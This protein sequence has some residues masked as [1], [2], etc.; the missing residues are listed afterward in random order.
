MTRAACFLAGPAGVLLLWPTAGRE[1]PRFV[2]NGHQNRVRR[3][4]L[5]LRWPCLGYICAPWAP[6]PLF[7]SVLSRVYFPLSNSARFVLSQYLARS[8]NVRWTCPSGQWLVLGSGCSSTCP[9]ARRSTSARAM[10]CAGKR[11]FG[12][13]AAA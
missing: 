13:R 8:G 7:L 5:G 2:Q 4:Q 6:G 9:P 12:N 11:A 10:D 3:W 1:R